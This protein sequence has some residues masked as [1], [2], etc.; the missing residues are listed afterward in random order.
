MLSYG[1]GNDSALVDCPLMFGVMIGEVGI[2]GVAAV[3]EGEVKRGETYKVLRLPRGPHGH[4]VVCIHLATSQ[5]KLLPAPHHQQ[6][7]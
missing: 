7:Y 3:H 1:F 6:L 4:N 5:S 2:C